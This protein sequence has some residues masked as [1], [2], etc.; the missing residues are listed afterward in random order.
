MKNAPKLVAHA[1][2]GSATAKR[3]LAISIRKRGFYTALA[4]RVVERPEDLLQML[5]EMA[6]PDG[7]ILLGFD[8]P[9]GL[10]M[11]YAEK[12][13]ITN[14]RAAL[15]FF[16]SGEWASFYQPARSTRQNQAAPVTSS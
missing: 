12:V 1:D 9:I 6:G 15:P 7:S 13:G 4:P 11:N 3:S 10:P 16:G 5:R 8:F 2:W 14:F